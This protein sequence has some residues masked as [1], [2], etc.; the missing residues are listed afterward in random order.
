MKKKVIVIIGPTASGKSSLGLAVADVLNGA[1]I[2]ADS[3]QIYR[4][5]DIGT[6]KATKEEMKR[7]P[8]YMIDICDIS[9]KYDAKTYKEAC[10]EKIEEVLAKGKVPIIVGGTGLY[11]NAVVNNVDFPTTDE[12]DTK[13]KDK[14]N[15]LSK[16]KTTEELFLLLQSLDIKR[17]EV[18]DKQNRRRVERALYLAMQGKSL[19]SSENNLW[20]KADSPYEF[21][22]I[23]IDMP[24]SLLYDKIEK[25]V[26]EMVEEGV[27]EEAKMLYNMQS[28]ESFT[29]TQAIGYKEFFD[30][31][32]GTKTLEECVDIL[33]VNTRH[34]AKRQITWFKKLEN[35]IVVDGTLPKR[36]LVEIIKEY[37][38]NKT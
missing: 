31:F 37:Y 38:E 18:V 17:A 7:T 33:K 6:A 3:M 15:E 30:Y 35:K 19:D 13:L 14:F 32:K 22:T 9:E 23:Y 4:K 12:V 8:H 27:L 25:R 34:Y 10:Y 16:T 24:R 1:I 2:S 20:K 11:I 5:L 29:A 36:E 28:K 21:I 26:D